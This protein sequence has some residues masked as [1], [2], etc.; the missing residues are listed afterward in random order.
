MLFE[1][2]PL[3]VVCIA[4]Q[5]SLALL[6][7]GRKTGLVVDCGEGASRVVPVY[8]GNV[9]TH[10]VDT[11][12]PGGKDFTESL[13]HHHPFEDDN[14][15]KAALRARKMKEKI[16]Y[17]AG[18]YEQELEAMK[19]EDHLVF[20]KETLLEPSLDATEDVS[21]SRF[22]T[23]QRKSSK[24]N[25]NL[26]NGYSE[27]LK[28]STA[29][30]IHQIWITTDMENI[31][32]DLGRFSC[33]ESLLSSGYG[34]QSLA[35]TILSSVKKCDMELHWELFNNIVLSGG[36]AMCPGFRGRLYKELITKAPDLSGIKLIS[37]YPSH[38]L[39]WRGGAMLAGMAP[40]SEYIT[41]REYDELGKSAAFRLFRI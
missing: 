4:N 9:L 11:S 26:K 21:L 40:Q 31:E 10:A 5:A 23:P 12:S 25:Q 28:P 33:M 7:C 17:V 37:P 35:D 22:M 36:S 18:D 20:E 15:L 24:E 27:I 30:Y 8:E 2:F 41:R 39:V 32:I 29:A 16:C 34:K 14:E 3:P 6:A 19:T 1:K 13:R 38:Q